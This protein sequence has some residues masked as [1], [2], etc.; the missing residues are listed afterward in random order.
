[1]GD[2]VEVDRSKQFDYYTEEDT[3]KFLELSKNGA[4]AAFI[5]A[6]RVLVG[7]ELRSI[8]D[9]PATRII[10]KEEKLLFPSVF[11]SHFLGAQVSDDG[12][13]CSITL[14]GK[15]ATFKKDEDTYKV[16]E[17]CGKLPISCSSERGIVYIPWFALNVFGI[18]AK[19]YYDGRLVVIGDDSVFLE[20]KKNPRL[21]YAASYA[22]TGDYDPYSFTHED[23]VKT[24]DRWRVTLVGSKEIN[25]TSIPEMVSKLEGIAN[26]CRKAL[27]Q[28]NRDK[29]AIIL[30]G[31]EAPTQSSDLSIQYAK[32]YSLAKAWGSYGNEFYHSESLKDD[33]LFGLEWMW[34]NMYGENEINGTGWR[35]VREFNWWDWFVGGV[36]PL[37]DTMLIIEEFLTPEDKEKYLKTFKWI[38]TFSRVGM[39][40]PCAMSR[41]VVCT[42]LALLTEDPEWLMKEYLDY[43]LLLAINESGHGP[44]I[45]GVSWTHTHPYN[46]QY[47]ANNVN[48]LLRVGANLS[49]TPVEF[50]SPRQYN[51]FF[52]AKYMFEAA[53]YKGRGFVMF[54][55]RANSGAEIS[56]SSNIIGSLLAMIGMF[57][58]D[59]DRHI[60]KMVK[61][62]AANPE[63]VEALK[64]Y[65]SF[66]DFAKLL[67]IL[68]DDTIPYESDY[69]LA[70]AWFTGDRAAQHRTNYCFALAMSSERGNNYESINNANKMG[71]YTGDGALF[72]YTD[73][74]RRAF[75]GINFISNKEL[76]YRIPGTTV[77]TQEREVKSLRA[78]WRMPRDFVGSMQLHR[79]YIIGAMDYESYHFEGPYDETPDRGYG[80]SLPLH[81]N[82][83]VAK[84]SW[85]MFD[86]E[87]VCLGAGIN[88]T[89]G[90]EVNTIAEHRRLIKEADGK[91]GQECVTVNGEPVSDDFFS[92]RY[93]G[94]KSVNLEGFAGIVFPNGEN[95]YVSKYQRREG[96][97]NEYL[98]RDASELSGTPFFE[99]R[100]EHG[101]NPKNTGY[102]Y[103]V[104][105]Y[106]TEEKLKSEADD[107][108]IISN[109]DKLQA[110]YEKNTK[111]TGMVFWSAGECKEISVDS[112]AL[113]MTSDKDGVYTF[114]V[115]DPT[116]KAKYA[117][118]KIA[119][120]L[121]L[122][123][124][125]DRLS[126]R[127][128]EDGV[129][130]T[131]DFDGSYARNLVA[132]FTE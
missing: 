95:I 121:K 132:T 51:L 59:E 32:L 48:R 78:G 58:E 49:G 64:T 42:K 39:L 30:F 13:S 94:A 8:G 26:E 87:C 35:N 73:T 14:G 119:K 46:M 117:K 23:Y 112:P 120:K 43:E 130:I 92:L 105:P 118:V 40:Q 57:G 62:N 31:T 102:A 15:S 28:M 111:V 80:G 24:K 103:V 77:D 2:W 60:K 66:D 90:F 113:V 19:E 33:I 3:A 68:K 98:H 101:K 63:F 125:N 106:A 116:Q 104:V 72:L 123:E 65:C 131:V 79:D 91:I 71:W 17:E 5:Y 1:M 97:Y 108:E 128:C 109:T 67:S 115:C 18:S 27:G 124:A 99:V 114:S 96:E 85:F 38:T 81:N 9:D 10:A 84:K 21:Q 55:G 16:G 12:E 37:T 6:K 69:T 20:M 7:G 29:N 75:D 88:S 86:D 126:V 45:D 54:N 83:L 44:H 53:I 50:F 127:E 56:I 74:D 107:V 76:A 47:G 36:M 41:I 52:L 129:E 4:I 93:S 11:F 25:D 34:A 89:T 110:V 22:V 61:R 100:I 82:D 122:T 70:H